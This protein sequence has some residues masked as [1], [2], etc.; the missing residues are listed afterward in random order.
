MQVT[1]KSKTIT[2]ATMLGIQAPGMIDR[3]H[4]FHSEFRNSLCKFWKEVMMQRNTC[5]APTLCSEDRRTPYTCREGF[6]DV[7]ATSSTAYQAGLCAYMAVVIAQPPGQTCIT[8]V[9]IHGLFSILLVTTVRLVL[10]ALT[11]PSCMCW[12][13]S[14]CSPLSRGAS[15]STAFPPRDP[16]IRSKAG[17]SKA[18]P[19]PHPTPKKLFGCK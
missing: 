12:L 6:V 7:E 11:S 8:T 13:V 1:I 2:P 15:S 17:S 19:Y 18:P 3:R 4:P 9:F 16:K 10:G 14:A 5:E